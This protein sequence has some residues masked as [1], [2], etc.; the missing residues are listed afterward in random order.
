ME[1]RSHEV[2]QHLNRDIYIYIY[3][4]Y[5]YTLMLETYS[6]AQKSRSGLHN[7]YRDNWL[8]THP[9]YIDALQF[10]KWIISKH[11]PFRMGKRCRAYIA[12]VAL[13]ERKQHVLPTLIDIATC[14]VTIRGSVVIGSTLSSFSIKSDC[15][16]YNEYVSCVVWLQE[17]EAQVSHD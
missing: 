17:R 15:E 3:I 10:A 13:L 11:E 7:P 5:T 8:A 4:Y 1:L 9:H 16:A 12:R 6:G 2:G 14:L